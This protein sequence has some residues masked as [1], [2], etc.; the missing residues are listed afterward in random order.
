MSETESDTSQAI[1]HR[2]QFD[3]EDDEHFANLEK[4]LQKQRESGKGIE[5]A[6]TRAN[7]EFES[8]RCNGR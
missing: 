7:S 6:L 4:L 1:E 5:E 3:R 8:S 2:I